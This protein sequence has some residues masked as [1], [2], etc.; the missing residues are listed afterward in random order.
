M[1]IKRHAEASIKALSKMFGAV[2]VTGARQAG[3]TTLL[4]RTLDGIPFVSMDDAFAL[5]AAKNNTAAF[6]KDQPAPVFIDEVQYAPQLFPYI[7][8]ELDR[9]RKKG[10]YYLSGSQQFEMMKDVT[11]SLAG[12]IGI[13][14]LPGL[15]LREIL[16][17]RTLEPFLPV[18][19]FF[20]QR[21]ETRAKASYDDIWHYIWR[22]SMPQ[23]HAEPETDW[24]R[25][26]GA[27][28]RTYIERDVRALS[29]VGDEQSFLA[30]MT[31]CAARTGSLLNYSDLARDAGISVPTAKR[32]CS[33]LVTSN[34]VFLL[35]PYHRNVLKR[36]IK[37]P[38]LY[39]MDTGLAAYLTRWNT[40]DTLKNGAMAGSLFETYV[41]SEIIKGYLNYGILDPPVWFFRDTHQ[42]EI[43]LLIEE[44][45]I[46]HPVEI[47]KYASPKREDIRAFSIL[48]EIDGMKRGEGALICLYDRIAS[49]SEM[50]KCIPPWYL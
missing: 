34:L 14:I 19:R 32:W 45:G 49:V 15:S 41:I 46:L 5:S 9:T 44:N 27:Y 42:T 12:R 48:D 39:F 17:D 13:Q 38:K 29:Q 26:Y 43:D 22:G 7:K 28:I 35:Q 37:A 31:A 33:I 40:P 2:I 16:S 30:F 3:K 1:Y 18:E 11:E 20:R 21:K 23:L 24:S 10:Q 4:Q 8:A 25:Y 36:V 6:M 50:D 47:K